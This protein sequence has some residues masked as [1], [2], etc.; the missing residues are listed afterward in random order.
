MKLNCVK[1]NHE[2]IKRTD[3]KP[4]TCPKCKNYHWEKLSLE[5]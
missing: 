5:K 3:K 1:C 2:W 4:K